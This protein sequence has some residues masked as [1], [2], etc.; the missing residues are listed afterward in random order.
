MGDLFVLYGIM[1]FLSS[2]VCFIYKWLGY[3]K[4]YERHYQNDFNTIDIQRDAEQQAYIDKLTRNLIKTSF[5]RS[6]LTFV[7]G[8]VSSLIVVLIL[9]KFL[10]FEIASNTS[11]F[12]MFRTIF[13]IVNV[14]ILVISIWV[15]WLYRDGNR[16]VKIMNETRCH[17]ASNPKEWSNITKYIRRMYRVS[18]LSFIALF[19]LGFLIF[20]KLF[21][22]IFQ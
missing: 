6:I 4:I 12:K 1:L 16:V 22:D 11:E 15:T 8:S 21:T 9:N 13:F 5:I 19:N 14:V 18:E 17:V 2:L 3:W 10:S 20:V 7:I